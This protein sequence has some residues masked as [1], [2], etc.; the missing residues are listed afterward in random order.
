MYREL[1]TLQY[2]VPKQFAFIKP[3]PTGLRELRKTVRARG[4]G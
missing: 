1:E 4:D 2:S 3:L